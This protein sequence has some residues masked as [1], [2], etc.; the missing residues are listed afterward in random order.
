MSR[1]SLGKAALSSSL[2]HTFQSLIR[3]SDK[4]KV[5]SS[6]AADQVKRSS[7]E[8]VWFFMPFPTSLHITIFICMALSTCVISLISVTTPLKKVE[9]ITSRSQSL[10]KLRL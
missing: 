1:V 3:H 9:Q 2:T 10:L 6:L 8:V 5:D 4:G 7:D